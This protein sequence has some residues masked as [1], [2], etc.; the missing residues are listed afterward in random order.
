MFFA[1]LSTASLPGNSDA[2]ADHYVASIASLLRW[3][4]T[5]ATQIRRSSS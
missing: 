2:Y 4:A 3:L 5:V 1:R